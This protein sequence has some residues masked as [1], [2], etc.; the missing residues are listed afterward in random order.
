MSMRDRNNWRA[1]KQISDLVQY[2]YGREGQLPNMKQSRN[3]AEDE[4]E[5]LSK[6]RKQQLPEGLMKEGCLEGEKQHF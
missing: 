1:A 5:K 3:S 4:E 6:R 2:K